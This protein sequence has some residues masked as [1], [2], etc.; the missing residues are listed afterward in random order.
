MHPVCAPIL[1]LI[2]D[3]HL[4]LSIQTFPALRL[5]LVSA[6]IHTAPNRHPLHICIEGHPLSCHAFAILSSQHSSPLIHSTFPGLVAPA[7]LRD[8]GHISG[9]DAFLSRECPSLGPADAASR[10]PKPVRS[11]NFFRWFLYFWHFFFCNSLSCFSRKVGIYFAACKEERDA[12]IMTRNFGE[13][14]SSGQFLS[15]CR[16]VEVRFLFF[17]FCFLVLVFGFFFEDESGGAWDSSS[18]PC[19]DRIE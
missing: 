2:Y 3:I 15:V 8:G 7:G 9:R 1:Y 19:G 12:M 13:D 18:P 11:T 17:F 14:G 10:N 6:F 5:Q 4:P 16:C